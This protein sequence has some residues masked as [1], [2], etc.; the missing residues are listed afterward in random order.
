[1]FG[2]GG[3]AEAEQIADAAD[4]AAGSQHLVQDFPVFEDG[5]VGSV[6]ERPSGP[7]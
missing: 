7:L 1:M 4:V 5:R 6:L 2:G 3:D